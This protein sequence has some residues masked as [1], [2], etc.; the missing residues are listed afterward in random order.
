MI[1][2]FILSVFILLCFSCTA[3]YTPFSIFGKWQNTEYHGN[4]GATDYVNKIPNGRIYIFEPAGVVKD[5]AN[6]RGTYTLRNDSLQ[7]ILNGRREHYRMYYHNAHPDTIA[8][9][10]VS[11]KYQFVCDEGCSETF[12]RRALK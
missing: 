2:T 1:R 7:I 12:V 8:L 6:N 4:D 10:P 5:S 3:Q 9:V 11:D